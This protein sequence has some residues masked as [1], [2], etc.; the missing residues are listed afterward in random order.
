MNWDDATVNPKTE[1]SISRCQALGGLGNL[2]CGGVRAGQLGAGEN[3]TMD[4]SVTTPSPYGFCGRYCS[5]G[6]W[7]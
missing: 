5:I 7:L 6:R 3:V 2:G 4:I 1:D